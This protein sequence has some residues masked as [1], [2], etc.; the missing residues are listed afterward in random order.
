MLA[1]ALATKLVVYLPMA[2]LAVTISILLAPAHQFESALVA[3]GTAGVGLS[4]AWF[5]VGSGSPG[6]IM[7]TDS[8]PRII[9][10]A[11]AALGI[12]L[13][14]PLWIYGLAIAIPSA[15]SPVLA[16]RVT[17][18]SRHDF[19]IV[20]GGRLLWAIKAQA[21][22]L[23][24]RAV[25]ALYI[26]L[27]ITLVGI[28]SPQSVAVFAG[29]ERLQRMAL[30]VLQAVPNYLQGWVGGG[31]S[32][33]E[34]LDRAIKSILYNGV[35]GIIA[36]TGFALLAPTFAHF[37]FSGVVALPYSLSALSGLLIFI[38]CVSRAT[39]NITLVAL[40]KINIISLSALTGAAVG[41]PAILVFSSLFGP[42]GALV[43]ELLAEGTV[44]AIQ[45]IAVV[46][47]RR[48]RGS[49]GDAK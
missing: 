9:A 11:A 38:V 42:H 30:T 49:N 31:K 48:R 15:L 2:A 39:G 19:R 45:L 3:A 27:P 14:G 32:I 24:G 6:R 13:G 29:A 4:S 41:V 47:Y 5:F 23:S 17:G 7:M 33:E 12:G 16:V 20:S 22:A 37:V 36:G 46:V 28:A 10:V 18:V 8:L 44:L 35:L 34:R 21:V 1:A 43:G 26:A 40:R 25:S